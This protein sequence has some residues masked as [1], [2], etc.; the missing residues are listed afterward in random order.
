MIIIYIDKSF[1]MIINEWL[2][3]IISISLNNINKIKVFYDLKY[4]KKL[5]NN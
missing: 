2:F 1:K 5:I 3:K 4:K